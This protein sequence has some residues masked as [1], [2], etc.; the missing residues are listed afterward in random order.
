MLA[1]S[2]FSNYSS[3]TNDFFQIRGVALPCYCTTL[4]DANGGMKCDPAKINIIKQTSATMYAA[5]V[6]STNALITSFILVMTLYPE[7]QQRA[8]EEIDCVVGTQRLPA[9]G[10]RAN[11]PYLECI[12]REVYRW[13]P[14]S[15]LSVP[16]KLSRN[17]EYESH[18]IPK[19]TIIIP[20]IWCDGSLPF[21]STCSRW[22]LSR[23]MCHDPEM[24][25]GPSTF[26]PSRF[27][28]LSPE[29]NKAI[30]PRNFVFGF[31]RRICPGQSLGENIIFLC[32]TSVLACFNIRKKVVGGIEVIPTI[33]YPHFV[34]RPQPFD[35]KI[36]L[37][38][39]E[40]AAL[41]LVNQ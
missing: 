9:I 10:D 13:N 31:G 4:L 20:N 11:L 18:M 23:A 37:R 17:D 38:S 3:L 27:L 40:A 25:P 36:S 7:I 6:D 14:A 29:K 41:V 32:I 35:C 21:C 5:G 33:D 22:F 28:D 16:H 24:Y 12:I 15:P 30:D 39:P 26:S 1:T 2:S 19:G 34:G 8:Q